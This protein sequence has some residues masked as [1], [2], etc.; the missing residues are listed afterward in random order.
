MIIVVNAR[1]DSGDTISRKVSPP[2]LSVVAVKTA[3]IAM[4]NYRYRAG[5]PTS[6]PT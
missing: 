4:D 2:G 6:I 1:P 3:T 5:P